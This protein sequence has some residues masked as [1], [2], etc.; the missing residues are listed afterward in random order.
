MKSA[1]NMRFHDCWSLNVAFKQTVYQTCSVPGMPTLKWV[2]VTF[3]PVV[4]LKMFLSSVLEKPVQKY[5]SGLKPTKLT[6]KAFSY[7]HTGIQKKKG[8]LEMNNAN[9]AFSLHLFHNAFQ[10]SV[11]IHIHCWR[12]GK[13]LIKTIYLSAT[14]TR[15]APA[16]EHAC[17][18][19]S[20]V[21]V[22]APML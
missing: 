21:F 10:I 8:N 2:N 7:L 18:A 19:S 6:R 13:L 16:A 9:D 4:H 20:N 3:L 15:L 11:R 12:W 22:S 14:S 5:F 1:K 17:F